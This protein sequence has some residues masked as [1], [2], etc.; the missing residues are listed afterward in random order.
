MVGNIP[1]TISMG[2][3]EVEEDAG[4]FVGTG[5]VFS[6]TWLYTGITGWF[7]VL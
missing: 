5:V 1:G 2:V 4:G 3:S 6:G 7:D